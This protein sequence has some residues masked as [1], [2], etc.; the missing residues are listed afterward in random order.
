MLSWVS[1]LIAKYR[2]CA[3]I[4]CWS[5]NSSSASSSR[6]QLTCVH[7][8]APEA[9]HAGCRSQPCNVK[10]AEMIKRCTEF[11]SIKTCLSIQLESSSHAFAFSVKINSVPWPQNPAGCLGAIWDKTEIKDSQVKSIYKVFYLSPLLAP[12]QQLQLLQP[13]LHAGKVM[14]Y[15]WNRRIWFRRFL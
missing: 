1:Q 12:Q 5:F 15:F 8:H 3:W 2:G 10:L 7:L 4:R 11:R 9:W 14:A 6:R 13:A